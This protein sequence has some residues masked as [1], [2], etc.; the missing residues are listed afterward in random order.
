MTQ[1]PSWDDWNRWCDARIAA[2]LAE[3]DRIHIKATGQALA[4]FRKQ[5]RDEIA[6]QIG[7]LRAELTIAKA[8]DAG[9][10]IDLPALPLRR[11]GD[12][13]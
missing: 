13:A 3:Q 6:E 8:H 9:R 7:L 11:R 1:Q 2:A 12:A 5:L 10:V 4:Q